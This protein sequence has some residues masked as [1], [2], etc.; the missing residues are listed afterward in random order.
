MIVRDLGFRWGSCG[1][2]RTLYFNW[3]LLQLPVQVIDYVVLHEQVHLLH[4]NHSKQFWKAMDSVLPDWLV[5]K[6]ELE[7]DWV[8]LRVSL[9]RLRRRPP[10]AK[11][12]P[13]RVRCRGDELPQVKLC[14]ADRQ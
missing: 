10:L 3:R 11:G 6:Q 14:E 13:P 5:R 8:A 4:H 9:W 2:H 12:L 1:K 7:R